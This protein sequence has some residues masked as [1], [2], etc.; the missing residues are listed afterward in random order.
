MGFKAS[1]F[2]NISEFSLL[3]VVLVRL[4]VSCAVVLWFSFLVVF[5]PVARTV[6]FLGGCYTRSPHAARDN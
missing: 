2:H 3:F 4:V 5:F 1:V 6:R